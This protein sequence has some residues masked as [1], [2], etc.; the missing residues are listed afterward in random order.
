MEK[1]YQ[2][3]SNINTLIINPIIIVLV[4]VSAVYFLYGVFEFLWK[5]QSDPKIVKQG[6]SHML[7]GLVGIF[8]MLSVF[9]FFKF[10]LNTLPTSSNTKDNVN[11]VLNID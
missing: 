6:T 9:G 3:L 11:K 7:W 10:L 4:G 5:S 8:V 2:I 1:V